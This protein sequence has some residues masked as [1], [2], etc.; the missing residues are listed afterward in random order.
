MVKF[1][2]KQP[3]TKNREP[4]TSGFT[5][6]E[7]LV[8]IVIISILATLLMANFIGVRQRARD[9]QRKSDLRQIQA[10]LELY[11]SDNGQYKITDN[12]NPKLGTCGSPFADVSGNIVYMKKIPCDPMGTTY[13]YW[14]GNYAYLSSYGND[15]DLVACLENTAD[16]EGQVA[17]T[18]WWSGNTCSTNWYYILHNP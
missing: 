3:T 9:G 10:A 16:P 18:N 7:L 11:R 6:I 17:P 5:L 15:Y 1:L 12:V 8:V 14:F 13:S 2:P 4:R